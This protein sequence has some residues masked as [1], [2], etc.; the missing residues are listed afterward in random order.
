MLAGLN[1]QTEAGEAKPSG[2][3]QWAT[4]TTGYRHSCMQEALLEHTTSS[5]H[6]FALSASG[7]PFRPWCW[8]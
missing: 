3:G 2:G 4:Q 1:D 5:Q 6:H 7:L 8:Q